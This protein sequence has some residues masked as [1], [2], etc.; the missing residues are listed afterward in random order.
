MVDVMAVCWSK[1]LEN[2]VLI[3]GRTSGSGWWCTD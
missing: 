1:V 2:T 3:G